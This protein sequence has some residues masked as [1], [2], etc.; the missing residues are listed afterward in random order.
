[1]E[2]YTLKIKLITTLIQLGG[3]PWLQ[4]PWT[5]KDIMFFESQGS[6]FSDIDMLYPYLISQ[7]P[8]G[9]L[10]ENSLMAH[11][12][13]YIKMSPPAAGLSLRTK[14]IATTLLHWES[15]YWSCKVAVAS[16]SFAL[17]KTVPL[18]QVQT[19]LWQQECSIGCII[20]AQCQRD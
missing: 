6:G 1:M 18:T 8:Q 10:N 4:K 20:G 12:Y 13:L 5:K 15:F 14:L 16:K 3:T 17:P 11:T 9:E 2:F 7:H 19:S